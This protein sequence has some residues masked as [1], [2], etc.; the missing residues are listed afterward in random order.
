[1]DFQVY[2]FRRISYICIWDSDLNVAA[3]LPSFEIWSSVFKRHGQ[4]T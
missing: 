4:E 1:M 3:A 2:P